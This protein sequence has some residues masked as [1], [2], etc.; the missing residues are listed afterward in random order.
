M[1]EARKG[2][3]RA[4]PWHLWVI[5]SIGFLWSC[6]GA[7]DYLMTST[8][9]EAYMSSFPAEKLEFFYAYPSWFIAFWAIAV[10]GGVVGA[11]LLLL[12]KKVAVWVFL[13]SLLGVVITA[14]RNY[15]FANGLEVVGSAFDLTIS[16]VVFVV[17]LGLF[18][19]SQKMSARGVLR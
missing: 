19:Y 18:F 12:R 8:R 2:S 9:N 17:A 4:T 15:V 7:M 6:M 1:S 5:G 14:I 3:E 16:A 11:I 13:A 10:W